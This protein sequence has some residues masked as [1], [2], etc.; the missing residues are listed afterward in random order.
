MQL[1]PLSKN[2]Q[3]ITF[4]KSNNFEVDNQNP[5]TTITYFCLQSTLTLNLFFNFSVSE[6]VVFVCLLFELDLLLWLCGTVATIVTL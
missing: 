1:N 4:D 5:R 2:P 6:V 3:F